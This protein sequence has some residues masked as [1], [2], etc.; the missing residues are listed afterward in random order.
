MG[1]RL[2]LKTTPPERLVLASWAMPSLEGLDA[3]ETKRF[4]S[5]KEAITDYVHGARITQ[6][7][8]AKSIWREVFYRAYDKCVALDGRGMPIGWVGLLPY[9]EIQPRQRRKP[10][11]KHQSKGLAGA[12]A[13]FLRQN[14]DIAAALESYLL[15]NAKR[16][17]GGEAGVRHKSVHMEF[18]RLCEAKDPDMQS[19]PFTSRRRGAG[20]VREFTKAFLIQHYDA[21][22]VTQYGYKA[23]TK[24][25]TGNG[26]GS[27]LVACM[28][29]DIVEM[30]EHAMGCIGTV[31][32]ETT[33]G[34]RFLDAGRMTLLLLVDRHKG[35]IMAFKVIFREA[36]NAGDAMDVLH[37]GVLGEPDWAHRKDGQLATR[38]LADL[39]DR[40]GWCGFNCLLLDNAL[41][42]LADE[43]VSRVMSLSG[44]AVNFGPMKTPARRQLVERIFNEL[45]R[46]GF[47]RLPQ[48]TGAGPQDPR[49][50][51][52]EEAARAC[53][54]SEREIVTLVSNLLRNFNEKMGKA[55][56]AASAAQRMHALICGPERDQY[57]FPFLP[58]LRE[59]EADLSKSIIT[60]PIRGNKGTG[61]RPYF[62]FLEVDYTNQ[63][64]AKDWTLLDEQVELQLHVA[65][66]N[67]RFI[68]AFCRQR[69]LGICQAGGRW[70][71]SDHS[72]DLRRQINQLL[73]EG[74]I[75]NDRNDDVV[76]AFLKKVADEYVR[77]KSKSKPAKAAMRHVGDHNARRDVPD[78]VP[79]TADQMKQV[80]VAV[81][82]LLDRASE[83]TTSNY[84]Q[85]DD[86]GAFNGDRHDD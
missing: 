34:F 59:G 13:Q 43:L 84:M 19:W 65:R 3:A 30:D 12:L 60:V 27:R 69:P 70:R 78:D 15:L 86:I 21:I 83:S 20:A 46:A 9:L 49:R 40:F 36:A 54:L 63:A 23:A 82:D 28:P 75:E 14:S 77:A 47:K 1:S 38:P 45:E 22:V 51:K 2:T 11:P 33:E 37:A 71:W 58:P 18:L 62:S 17:P 64:M 7:L 6:L 56:L 53:I 74:Y 35:W 66:T 68:E 8:Q 79:N 24:A 73:R 67:I 42:H 48:T 29:M 72:I 80:G 50:Q 85:W 52:A 55:N 26:H 39:D 4:Y 61:R 32:I 76:A 44:C 57:Q 81:T 5:L 10:L 31:R 41:I 16:K 25:K